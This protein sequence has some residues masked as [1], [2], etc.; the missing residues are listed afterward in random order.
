MLAKALSGGVESTIKSSKG[1]AST[2][3]SVRGAAFTALGIGVAI[4][5]AKLADYVRKE[6]DGNEFRTKLPTKS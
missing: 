4:G 2:V 6:M 1:F 5:G 3:M